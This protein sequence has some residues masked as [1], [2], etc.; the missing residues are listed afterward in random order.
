[1][2]RALVTVVLCVFA[3]CGIRLNAQQSQ[4]EKIPAAVVHSGSDPVGMSVADSLRDE[5]SRSGRYRLVDRD[6][7]LFQIRIVTIDPS[8][9]D[10]GI[11]TAIAVTYLA[12]NVLPV[13]PKNPQTWLP[14]YLNDAIHIAG[15]DQTAAVAQQMVAEL[16][17]QIGHY[18][19]HMR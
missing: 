8:V 16:D 6:R 9:G 5:L 19:D 10:D 17:Q 7:A 13:E 1:M 15:R 2:K 18:A 14:I 4:D 3:L 11:S 12:A